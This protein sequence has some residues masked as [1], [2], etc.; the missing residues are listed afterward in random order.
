MFESLLGALLL[1]R[2]F[3]VAQDFTLRVLRR[4]VDWAG[5]EVLDEEY[6]C[7]RRLS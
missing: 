3:A 2:G 5:L 7:R 6:R 4:C 1:D